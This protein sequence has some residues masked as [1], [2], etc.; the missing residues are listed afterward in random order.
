M[1]RYISFSRLINIQA[2]QQH[3]FH[4]L[5]SSKLPIITASVSGA[6]ALTLIAKL[7]AIGVDELGQFSFIALQVLDPLFA[8]G[9]L[10]HV[11]ANLTIL[12]LLALLSFAMWA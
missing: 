5:T 2:T 6:L 7:H 11:S 4:V 3:P 12:S 1:T 10:G 9:A 8:V